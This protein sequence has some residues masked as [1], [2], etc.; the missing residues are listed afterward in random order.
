MAARKTGVKPL[1]FDY[2]KPGAWLRH[3]VLVQ[4]A[5]AGDE[6][7]IETILAL[8]EPLVNS[9]V[10]RARKDA[11][12]L[13]EDDLRQTARMA[14]V[15]AIRAY[16]MAPGLGARSFPRFVTY[17]VENAMNRE[18][19]R[20]NM[21]RRGGR[22]RT[23]LSYCG[24]TMPWEGRLDE[25]MHYGDE[26]EGGTLGDLLPSGEDVEERAISNVAARDI[27]RRLPPK[28]GSVV[29]RM[30]CGMLNNEIAAQDGMSHEGPRYHVGRAVEALA[31]A[32]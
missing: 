6:H 5:C 1:G 25:P 27:L 24:G 26:G 31:E 18:V 2:D 12:G 16:R 32:A 13:E 14:I 10:W 30:A 23:I 3:G 11:P 4:R 17:A 15:L 22:M 21:S 8:Y 19:R 28:A 20:L 7:A 29:V 9:R